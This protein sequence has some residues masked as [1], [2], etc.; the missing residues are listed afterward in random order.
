MNGKDTALFSSKSDEWTTPK[1]LFEL[2]DKE[3]MFIVDAAAKDDNTL[4]DFWFKDAL[5]HDWYNYPFCEG[6]VLADHFFLNPPYSQIAAFMK[7]A[8]EESLKGAT[9]ICLIPA[10]TDTK[11]WHDYV[12]KAAEIRF[13]KGRLK[14]GDQ[15]NSA[16]F[17]SVVV[18]FDQMSSRIRSANQRL[19]D[20]DHTPHIGKTITQPKKV[21]V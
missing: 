2:L 20:L 7:K 19:P 21:K 6:N 17:P 15:V 13:I 4:C 3:F 11:Y 18:I 8:Y 1:W 9:I 12:M 10:R 14:F 5:T 16:P